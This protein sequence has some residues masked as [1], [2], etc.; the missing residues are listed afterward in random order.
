[1]TIQGP[2]RD[3]LAEPL[4]GD[5]LVHSYA[6]EASLAEALSIYAGRGLGKGEAVVLVLADD[7]VA[8]LRRRLEAEGFETADLERWGQ[9][10]ILDAEE[11]LDEFLLH[12]MPDADLFRTL[13]DTLV[14]DA[15]SASRAGRIRVFGEMVNLLWSRGDEGAALALEGLWNEAIHRHR[16]PLLCAYRTVEGR[17]LSDALSDAHTHVVPV[18]ACA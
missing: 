13:S 15:R 18:S 14:G 3:W 7:H 11:L 5:H 8:A 2:W 12:G 4:T 10:R 17:P 16:M 6:D 9:L 1:L